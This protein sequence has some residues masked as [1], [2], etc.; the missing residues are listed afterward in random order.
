MINQ[1]TVGRFSRKELDIRYVALKRFRRIRAPATPKS[2]IPQRDIFQP[3]HQRPFGQPP[4]RANQLT[5]CWYLPYGRDQQTCP[6][7]STTCI[8]KRVCLPHRTLSSQERFEQVFR[9]AS[10]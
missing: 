7:Q 4:S 1:Q 2:N 6:K 8:R 3:V 9:S 10:N 5:L